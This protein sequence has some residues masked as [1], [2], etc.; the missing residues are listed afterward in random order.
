MPAIE[1]DRNA[2]KERRAIIAL[3]AES[4]SDKFYEMDKRVLAV[5]RGERKRYEIKGKQIVIGRASP[6]Y[7]VDVDLTDAGVVPAK[8]SR[9][10][11][12][13]GAVWW[14]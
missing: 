14:V 7:Q 11:V 8:I 10:H 1:L 3:E 6:S 4:A 13:K 2:W 9:H 12:R 5:L